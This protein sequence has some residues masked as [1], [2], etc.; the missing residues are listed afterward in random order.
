MPRRRQLLATAAGLLAARQAAAQ[1]EATRIIVNFT[2]GGSLD[3]TARLLAE[4]AMRDGRGTVVVENRPGAGGNIGAA[5]VARAR[6]D[7]RTLLAALDTGLTVNPHLFRDMGFDPLRDLVPVAHL[8]SFQLVLLVHPAHPATDLRSFLEG[9][10][11]SPAF[12]AS[13]SVGSPGHLAMEHLRQSAGLPTTAL[14]HVPQRGNPEALTAIVSGT[15]PAGFLAIG[16]G[17]DLVRSGRLRALAVSGAERAA[18]LPEVPTVAESGFPGFEVRVANLLL[19]P[20]GTPDAVLAEWATVSQAAMAGEAARG[21]LPGWGIDPW[22]G[23]DLPALLAAN[24]ARWGRVVR[25][26]GM[27]LD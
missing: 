2:P 19:A 11:R 12:Y 4:H 14:E 6:P 10:R 25:E 15:V 17:P 13:G 16:G 8:G 1:A 20:R 27:R 18:V 26:A 23:G 9:A 7:G 24:N 3:G 5:A 21:R 22:P